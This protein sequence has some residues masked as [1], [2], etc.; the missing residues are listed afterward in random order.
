M[1][2]HRILTAQFRGIFRW[3][4]FRVSCACGAKSPWWEFKPKVG[5]L[6][7]GNDWYEKHRLEGHDG[8]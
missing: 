6:I 8:D 7:I 4:K 3:K 1:I 5:R 2:E